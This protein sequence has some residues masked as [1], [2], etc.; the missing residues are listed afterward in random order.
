MK[1]RQ[2]GEVSAQAKGWRSARA[3]VFEPVH[4]T[5]LGI[6]GLDLGADNDVQIAVAVDVA[7]CRDRFRPQ[8]D[9]VEQTCRRDG[10][11]AGRCLVELIE[12]RRA[13]LH[14]I[15]RATQHADDQIG[16]AVA[17]QVTGGRRVVPACLERRL[18]R[19]RDSIVVKVRTRTGALIPD[20]QE[21]RLEEVAP[22]NVG[23]AVAIDVEDRHRIGAVQRGRTLP[24]DLDILEPLRDQA[25]PRRPVH[26]EVFHFVAGDGAVHATEQHIELAVAIDV[27][28]LGDV[29]AV[30]IDRHAVDVFQCVGGNLKARCRLRSN[31]AVIPNVAERGLGEEIV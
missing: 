25:E 28:E 22:Q 5:R 9:V 7:K 1:R 8:I 12:I 27:G 20:P 6:V 16:V 26:I 23:I 18:W 14:R 17:V 13:G 29:L 4:P 31:V 3:D 15:E 21:T 10:P 19:K 30:G 24:D 11:R 2:Y